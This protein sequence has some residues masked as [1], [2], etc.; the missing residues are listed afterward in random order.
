MPNYYDTANNDVKTMV[1]RCRDYYAP[2][3]F[4]IVMNIDTKPFT[5]DIQ[6][7]ENVIINQTSSVTSE[8]YY[9]A[10]PDH[11][12]L[13]PGQT[14]LCPAYEADHI[15]KQLVDVIVLRNRG[16]IIA[17]G[18]TPQESAVDPA[19]QNKY[20]RMIF[21]GKKDFMQDYNQQNIEDANNMQ[22]ELE[23]ALEDEPIK[24]TVKKPVGSA[25]K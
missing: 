9:K 13:E 10:N 21:Q 16:K 5:Y 24:D 12:V 6:R 25:K 23:K 7:P 14:R 8:L 11:I 20:I 19:T 18:G 4:V 1:E 17:D 2:E 22:Q 3:D 15:I